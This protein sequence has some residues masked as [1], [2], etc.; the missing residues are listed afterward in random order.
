MHERHNAGFVF[1]QKLS[2]LS[3]CIPISFCRSLKFLNSDF[4]NLNKS[5]LLI[6]FLHSNRRRFINEVW[7]NSQKKK[8]TT[9]ECIIHPDEKCYIYFG[10]PR[11]TGRAISE[12]YC[13]LRNTDKH[14]DISLSIH[15]QFLFQEQ[16]HPL[17]I[18]CWKLNIC[19]PI[20]FEM[21]VILQ[22]LAY[23]ICIIDNRVLNEY[24]HF[25][26]LDN[27][28]SFCFFVGIAKQIRK[29]C[30]WRCVFTPHHIF[31]FKK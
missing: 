17:H 18:E 29:L 14:S 28:L 27:F 6:C 26:F 16:L 4:L 30:V 22:S 20:V 24:K 31:N 15:I 13:E 11:R 12:K 3:F 7:H 19:F 1:A 23:I 2:A 10:G 8:K 9:S 5:F 25:C 21:N